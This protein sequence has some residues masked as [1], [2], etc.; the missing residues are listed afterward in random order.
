MKEIGD[1][2]PAVPAKLLNNRELFWDA[3]IL[4]NRIFKLRF[5]D[6][7]DSDLTTLFMKPILDLD[8]FEFWLHEKYGNYEDSGLSTYDILN[9]N[10]GEAV[11]LKVK[12]LLA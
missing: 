10:Y 3:Y 8:K 1:P 4:F 6:F 5:H 12:G 11:T 7:M 2:R 9:R